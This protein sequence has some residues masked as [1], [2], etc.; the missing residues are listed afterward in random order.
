MVKAQL[1]GNLVNGPGSHLVHAACLFLL[2]TLN[3]WAYYKLPES[4][5][6][7]VSNF[8]EKDHLSSIY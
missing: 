5:H 7:S 6:F 1:S 4:L 3:T 2:D 8:H